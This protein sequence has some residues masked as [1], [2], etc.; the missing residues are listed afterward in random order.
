VCDEVGFSGLLQSV[1]HVEIKDNET[2]PEPHYSVT[3][4]DE[5]QEPLHDW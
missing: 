2:L 1:K 4:E 3:S 5:K